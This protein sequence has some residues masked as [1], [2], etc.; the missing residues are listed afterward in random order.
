VV[1][2]TTIQKADCVAENS[3]NNADTFFSRL[4]TCMVIFSTVISEEEV[5]KKIHTV[6]ERMAEMRE[7]LSS[8]A[9]ALTLSRKTF[10]TSFSKIFEM[11]KR[12]LVTF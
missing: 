6:D 11:E 7:S 3:A 9:G 10:T 12:A 4:A 5:S 2:S 1:I 8:A